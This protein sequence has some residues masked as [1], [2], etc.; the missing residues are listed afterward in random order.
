[1]IQLG[2]AGWNPEL[3]W[4]KARERQFG[5]GI[6]QVTARKCR[7]ESWSLEFEIRNLQT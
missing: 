5:F 7:L 1:M 2:N 4:N 3:A 6:A